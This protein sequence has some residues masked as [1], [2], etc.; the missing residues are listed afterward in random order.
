MIAKGASNNREERMQSKHQSGPHQSVGLYIPNSRGHTEVWESIS[1]TQWAT[2]ERGSRYP[3]LEGPQ[4]IC[5]FEICGQNLAFE[6]RF[7]KEPKTHHR[8][9]QFLPKKN[10]PK[11]V[12]KKTPKTLPQKNP[13]ITRKNPRFLPKNPFFFLSKKPPKAY[14]GFLG[15]KMGQMGAFY[16]GRNWYRLEFFGKK[17]GRGG[18]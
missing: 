2:P 4:S 16:F 15:T 1:P 12:T 8:T 18:W 3:Q 14:G 5:G 11:N 13:N 17:R 9:T 7:Q 10:P 6:M